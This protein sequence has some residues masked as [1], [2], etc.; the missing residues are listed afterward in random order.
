MFAFQ[1]ELAQPR[2]Q[3]LQV[4]RRL[5]VLAAPHQRRISEADRL[6]RENAQEMTALDARFQSTLF[7][8]SF[9]LL[10][11][12][13]MRPDKFS[14]AR[15]EAWKPWCRKFK[16]YT[17]GKAHGFRA[18]LEWAEEHQRPIT[19]PSFADCPWGISIS[20]RE[21]AR[22]PLRDS[23]RCGRAARRHQWSRGPRF[24]GLQAAVRQV[25]PYSWPV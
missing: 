17:Y 5:G 2:A 11:L 1:T 9:D 18:A 12:E 14:G 24:R 22:L 3:A 23:R 25:C 4:T 6:F 15:N 19:D 16:A 21:I 7:R 8:Q 10:D 13:S 20:K